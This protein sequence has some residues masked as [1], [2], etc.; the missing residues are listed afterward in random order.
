MRSKVRAQEK[1]RR[2]D[3]IVD[4]LSRYG[5]LSAGQL[6]D[7]L[8]V[9]VQTVRTDLRELDELQLIKRRHGNASLSTPAENIG[10]LP[11]TSLAQDDKCRIAAKVAELV[12]EGASLAIGTG[13]TAE[14]VA[15]AL[16]NKQNLFVATNNIHAVLA[17]RA[18]PSVTI[19]MAG[20]KVRLRDLD[21]IG[22][23]AIEFF[24]KYTVDIAIFSIGGLAEDGAIL[25]FNQDEVR[26]RH[27]IANCAKQ[28]I[29]VLDSTKIGRAATCCDGHLADYDIVVHTGTLSPTAMKRCADQGTKLIAV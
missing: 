5:E 24:A 19:T 15:R 6:A 2:R 25:D 7:F 21:F 16:I 28:R 8:N 12:P 26:A 4:L 1:A 18:N 10:Y 23:E 3:Q 17:L 29:L 14:E 27:A 11:R 13:T 20:G 9:T 22:A